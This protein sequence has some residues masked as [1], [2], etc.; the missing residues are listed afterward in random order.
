MPE[1]A[2][3]LAERAR[4][5]RFLATDLGKLYAAYSKAIIDY[6]RH[7]ADESVSVVKLKELDRVYREKQREFV[8]KLMDVAGL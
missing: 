3:W 4:H 2:D 6:W 7:D 1:S 5:E 8:I